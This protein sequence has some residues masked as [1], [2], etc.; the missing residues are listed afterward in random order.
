MSHVETT[1]PCVCSGLVG[2]FSSSRSEAL[3]K[4]PLGKFFSSSHVSICK[5]GIFEREPVSNIWAPRAD[6]ELS[7]DAQFEHAEHVDGGAEHL[8]ET[9]E[10]GGEA[11]RRVGDFESCLTWSS[12]ESING[13]FVLYSTGVQSLV[14]PVMGWDDGAGGDFESG[15]ING[16]RRG[17]W[18]GAEYRRY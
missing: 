3:V 9:R 4:K 5:N 14:R 10:S 2:L 17:S 1:K 11:G 18:W 13:P 15:R 12:S 8:F 7:A 16:S 6:N